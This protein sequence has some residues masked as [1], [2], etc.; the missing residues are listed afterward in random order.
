MWCLHKLRSKDMSDINAKLEGFARLRQAW[1]GGSPSVPD[2]GGMRE[3]CRLMSS[4]R[5]PRLSRLAVD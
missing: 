5:F 4:F 3:K 2:G 1:P